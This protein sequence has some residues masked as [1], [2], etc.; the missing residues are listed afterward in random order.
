MGKQVNVWLRKQIERHCPH[1][2]AD[3][4]APQGVGLGEDGSS[5]INSNDKKIRAGPEPE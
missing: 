3:L 5:S 2:M 4:Y 1:E